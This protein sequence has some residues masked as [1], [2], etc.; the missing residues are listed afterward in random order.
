[1][2]VNEDKANYKLK[3]LNYCILNILK[4]FEYLVYLQTV[5]LFAESIVLYMIQITFNVIA[6]ITL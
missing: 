4:A 3:N 5:Y 6:F 1:M 2:H